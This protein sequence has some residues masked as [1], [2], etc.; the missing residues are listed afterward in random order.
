MGK[1]TCSIDGCEN[2]SKSRGWCGKHYL[3]W[4][5]HGDPTFVVK[6]GGGTCSVELCERPVLSNKLC[7]PH[8]ARFRANGNPLRPCKSCG[9]DCPVGFGPKVYC[10]DECIPS[11]PAP[12][13]VRKVAGNS[14]F[15][16]IHMASIY[17]HGRLPVR[18]WAKDKLCVVCGA[19]DWPGTGRK[20]CSAAC[21][22]L[23]SNHGGVPP[24]TVRKCSRCSSELDLTDRHESGRKTRSDKVMCRHCV[25]GRRRRYK[26]SVTVLAD[27]DGSKCGICSESVD[28]DLRHP[29]PMSPS[30]DHIIPRSHGGSDEPEN[31]QLS[32]LTCNLTKQAR[33][34]YKVS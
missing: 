7:Q 8:D 18:T 13:C 32:H 11:C 27:R 23:L 20:T 2:F 25:N 3:R 28:L 1:S 34:D 12:D 31:L 5:N 26:F 6:R 15:C 21:R 17:R 4:F 19:T 24:E 30:V 9:V 10:S 29:N 22:T 14:E 33:I 16:N